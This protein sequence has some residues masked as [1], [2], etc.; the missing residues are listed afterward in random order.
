MEEFD[1]KAFKKMVKE[2][3]QND[4]PTSWC[5]SI[6]ED[7]KGDYTKV[8]W[9][10]L[11]SN[12]YLLEY[13]SNNKAEG[14]KAIVVGCGVGD[15]A[16]SLSEAGYKV[17]AF[18]ISSAAIDLCK[19]RYENSKI[20]F[21]VADLFDYPISWFED[22]DLVYE[23]NTIQ[24]LAGKYRI[25]ARE[26]ISSLLKKDASVLVSCRSRREGQ[27]ENDIPKPLD[28]KEINEFVHKDKLKEVFFVSYYDTQEPPICHFF[29]E[30]KKSI[31]L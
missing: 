8:F 24:V 14:K 28:K 19:K 7:V 5:N 27:Q 22:Y 16:F 1:Y 21:L 18:D 10:D 13:I 23:C 31:F 15:D 17:T 4:E 9:S 25:L 26:K 6:Y 3:Q 30:Y 2:H 20:D 29:A 12:P 11:E